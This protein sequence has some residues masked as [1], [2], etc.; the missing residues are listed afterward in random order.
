MRAIIDIKIGK[1]VVGNR[2]DKGLQEAISS[3]VQLKKEIDLQ[4]ENLKAVREV[5]VAKA[6]EILKDVDEPGVTLIDGD[7]SV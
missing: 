3:F 1:N 6:K 7:D 2:K 4:N 5:L